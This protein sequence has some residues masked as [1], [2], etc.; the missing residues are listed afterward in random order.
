MR[1]NTDQEDNQLNQLQIE[2]FYVMHPQNPF[3]YMSKVIVVI[4]LVPNA[5]KKV[6]T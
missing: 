2:S 1:E 6:F 4:L 3:Y 5:V